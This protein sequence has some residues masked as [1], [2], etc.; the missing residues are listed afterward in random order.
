MSKLDEMAISLN[1]NPNLHTDEE[2][3]LARLSYKA[4][5]KDMLNHV[6][7]SLS[8]KGI[9]VKFLLDEFVE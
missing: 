1:N 5:A 7:E 6:I 3:L 4:G 2:K 9:S 8:N